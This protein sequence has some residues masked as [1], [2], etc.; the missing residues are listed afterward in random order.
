M[1]SIENNKKCSGCGACYNICPVD[2][3]TMTSDEEG[4]L[5][6]VVD[7]EKCIHCNLCDKVCPYI[8]TQYPNEDLEY[9]VAAYNTHS[10]ER[11]I[12][13]S[14][15]IFVLLAKAILEQGGIVYGAAYDEDWLVSHKGVETEE[16][17]NALIGSKYVQSNTRVVYR[18]IKNCLENGKKVLFAGLS[19]Q[20]AGLKKY[21]KYDM[22][23]LYCVDLICLGV[24]SPQIWLDFLDLHFDRNKIKYINFKDKSLGWHTFS[25]RIDSEDQEYVKEGNYAPFFTGYFRSLYSRPSCSEC[26]FKQGNKSSDITIADCWG[27]PEIAPE[28]DD[29]KGLSSIVVHSDRGMQ[30]FEL[31]KD[32]LCWKES[33][34]ELVK[35][36]NKNYCVPR[37]MGPEREAFWRDYKILSK[38]EVFYRYCTKGKKIGSP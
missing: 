3:V 34:I 5:Y 23:G 35:V 4:F 8:E 13:S 26:I 37:E 33:D 2:A 24:P 38:Q 21:L 27:Y 14:G 22:Q 15:G 31:I 16:G 6:P 29:N 25:L 30:L 18:E 1:I 9:C 10:E 11:A 19:C 12:S 7:E 32:N 28:L 36:H 20:V 17:L